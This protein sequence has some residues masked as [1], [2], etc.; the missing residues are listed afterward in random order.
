MD[1]AELDLVSQYFEERESQKGTKRQSIESRLS[2]I[3]FAVK[4]LHENG[5]RLDTITTRQALQVFKTIRSMGPAGDGGDGTLS[6]NYTR[7]IIVTFKSFLMWYADNGGSL[8]EKKI[9]GV[10]APGMDF[11]AKSKDDILTRDEVE[12]VIE[13]CTTSRD[14]AIIATLYD[15][16]FRPGEIIGLKWG[17]LIRDDY[18]IRVMFITPKTKKER[19]IRFTYAVPF[20]NQWETDYPLPVT[21]DAPL[22]TQTVRHSHIYAP[23]TKDGLA[24]FIR[25]L[26]GRIENEEIKKKL[27]PSIFRPSKITHDVE[28]GSDVSYICM[29]NWGSL[30]TPMIDV[31]AKPGQGYIDRIALEGAGIKHEVRHG[32]KGKALAPVQC[33]ECGTLNRTGA[34]YC[35]TCRAG[36]TEDATTHKDTMMDVL[37]RL[38]KEDP[39]GLL[40]AL[41]KS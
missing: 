32:P 35:D 14:R 24:M 13:A 20:L 1:P 31:Y 23:L 36:L 17:D 27:S 37:K 16:S 18:G 12:Q 34:R 6:Q 5:G 26:R 29:K 15:G 25:R 28:D 4:I 21:P 40:D 7:R 22:F 8:E 19:P 11:E 33:P 9:K 41:K 39:A 3:R 30:K 38:A 2:E 10:T